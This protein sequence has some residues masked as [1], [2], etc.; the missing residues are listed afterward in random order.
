MAAQVFI[1]LD[2]LLERVGLLLRGERD[3]A[4]G[5]RDEVHLR[6]V[7]RDV[8]QVVDLSVAISVG[9]EDIARVRA[10][11]RFPIERETSRAE[12]KVLLGVRRVKVDA[13]TG[14]RCRKAETRVVR[15]AS[16]R[17]AAP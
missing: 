7:T 13:M 14:R 9:R 11:A 12:V 3:P 1:L 16:M 4:L 5:E 8:D 15:I 2:V 6:R 17:V 10:I